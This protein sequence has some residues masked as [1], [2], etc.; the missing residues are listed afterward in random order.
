MLDEF[1]D[2]LRSVRGLSDNT[3][4][5]YERDVAAYLEFLDDRD[6]SFDSASRDESRAYIAELS[7]SGHKASSINRSISAL[8]SFYRCARIS[9]DGTADPFD[10]VTLLKGASSLPEVLNHREIESILS[11]IGGESENFASIR[12]RA[13]FELLYSTGCRVS[14]VTGI[15]VVDVDHRRGTV[16]VHGKGSKDRLVFLGE[17]SHSALYDYLPYREAKS[18][19]TEQALFLNQRG[20]RLTRGGITHIIRQR[21][22][23]QKHISP[24][25]FRHSFATHVLDGGADIR[26]VQEMLGHASLSTTQVYTHLGIERLKTVY[27]EAHPHGKRK[28]NQS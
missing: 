24:H 8:R 11:E 5:S 27:R 23:L 18:A 26:T 4:R 16:L 21:L 14:E 28:R 20:H 7:R 1:V 12:D 10:S 15:N 2:Y 25:T 6:L 3:I 19:A 17:A 22:K 13:L 9:T